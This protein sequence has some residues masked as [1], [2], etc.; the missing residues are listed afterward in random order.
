M[1]FNQN[2]LVTRRRTCDTY[3][4]KAKITSGNIEQQKKKIKRCCKKYL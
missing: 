4:K 2:S 1:E 3:L